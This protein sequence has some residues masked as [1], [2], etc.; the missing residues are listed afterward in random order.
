MSTGDHNPR[1]SGRGDV[2]EQRSAPSM[3]E[4]L[5][6]GG[7]MGRLISAMDWSHSPLGSPEDWPPAL[8]G[9]LA[10]L[11][12]CPQPMFLAWGTNLLFFFNDAYRPVM[13]ARFNGQM[14]QP[15]AELWPEVWTTLGPIARDAL[16]GK[17][18]YH[19]N[20][21]LTLMR[22]GYAEHTW[23]SFSYAPLRDKTG[24]VTGI[25]CI[26]ANT[27]EQVQLTQ[28]VAS[29]KI[30]ETF[31]VEL[32]EALRSATDPKSLVGIA[33]ERLGLYLNAACVGYTEVDALGEWG[34][35]HHDWTSCDLPDMESAYRLD[36]LDPAM[37]GALEAGR[38]IAVND[39]ATEAVAGKEAYKTAHEVV[40]P[41]AFIDAPLIKEGRL[42]AVL[43]VLSAEPRVWTDGDKATVR[44]VAERTWASLRRLQAELTLR[45]TNQ[46]L[47]QRTTELLH[48]ETA[49]R[50]SQKL[51]ALG[52]LTGGVAHDFNNL[53]AVISSSV[54]LLRSSKLP[55][56]SRGKYLDMIFDTVAR[57][58]K[59]TSQ[60][61]AF[62]RQQPLTPKVFNVDEHVQGVIDLMRPLMGAQVQIFHEPCGGS[63]CFAEADISQFETA[64]VNLAINARDAMNAQG[65]LT[66]KVHHVNAL[67]ASARPGHG[68]TPGDFVAISVADT[69]CGIAAEKL[70]MI[71]EPF[72]TT[73]EVGK[74]TG[75]GLSQVFG[76]TKQSGGEVEVKSELGRGTV[77][78]VYLP[79]AESLAA[80]AAPVLAELDSD[81]Q[82]TR[83][84]VVED[85]ETLAQMTCEI[86][87]ALGYATT[88]AAN[89]AAALGLLAERHDRFDL[90]FSDVIM[91]GMNGIEF[92]QLVRKRYPSLPVV[93]TS[94]YSAIM[95]EEGTHGFELIAKPYTSDALVR[96]FGKAMAA[97]KS[98]PRAA[99]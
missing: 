12:S 96:A 7:S 56:A 23:W 92:G 1:S 87:N 72:Y 52:Q 9:G 58:V 38:T 62:A 77:F 89:A 25:S 20:M 6:H 43:F 73:K 78:T 17:G 67:P 97:Q 93:L 79:C 55:E 50:Q 86:L 13:G 27:T 14:G 51:E 46:A 91:P 15:F 59:L 84:L 26:C 64:L 11:L 74:G 48:T 29:E 47:D 4:F 83:L 39:T 24:K 35:V 36:D 37:M 5:A 53:L 34:L 94:G 63:V 41:R 40:G 90:V 28:H 33:A 60:L 44:E 30:R 99:P 8:K 45:E 42:A 81:A 31:W 66:I 88:W 71:F 3:P 69:G 61:L 65:E 32:N 75:L 49:L 18:T 19:E 98:M 70:G 80:P 85:N 57:A 2:N 82:G 95:A 68:P 76:F 10:T 22:N 21:P 16:D 54:E